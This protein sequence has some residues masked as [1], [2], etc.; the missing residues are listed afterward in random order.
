MSEGRAFLS[1]KGWDNLE[2]YGDQTKGYCRVTSFVRFQQMCGQT[3]ESHGVG[4]HQPD[5]RK[6]FGTA[7]GLSNIRKK[8]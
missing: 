4:R 8:F 2:N 3:G 7:I 5:V 1:H 6:K